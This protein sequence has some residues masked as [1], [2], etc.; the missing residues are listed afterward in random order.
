MERV[1]DR[2]LAEFEGIRSEPPPIWIDQILHRAVVEVN[3]SGDGSC[4][5]HIPC[6]GREAMSRRQ[7]RRFEMIVD[8]PFLSRFVINSRGDLIYG[9]GGGSKPASVGIR[10]K[11]SDAH[12]CVAGCGLIS[13]TIGLMLAATFWPLGC[14]FRWWIQPLRGRCGVCP[15]LLLATVRYRRV[16]VREQ[17]HGSLCAESR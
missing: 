11:G 13:A 9:M 17:N 4:G 8:R 7:P 12:P 15:S 10:W 14:L 1:F 3:E 16:W 2:N 6:N 5:S